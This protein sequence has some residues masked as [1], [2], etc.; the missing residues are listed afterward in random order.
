MR[1]T[2]SDTSN[3][4]NESEDNKFWEYSMSHNIY[5]YWSPFKRCHADHVPEILNI[6]NSQTLRL[7]L[8]FEIIILLYNL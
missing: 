6:L 3:N 7:R 8:R 1:N 2:V 4:K 5:I